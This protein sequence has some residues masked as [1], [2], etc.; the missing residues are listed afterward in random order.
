MLQNNLLIL[1]ASA[2]V[3]RLLETMS[4][5]QQQQDDYGQLAMLSAINW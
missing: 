5:T 1:S 4:T 3:Y 2:D